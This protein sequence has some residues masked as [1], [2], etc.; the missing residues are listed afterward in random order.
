MKFILIVICLFTFILSNENK[1]ILG[2]WLREGDVSFYIFKNDNTY[3]AVEFWDDRY[4]ESETYNWKSINYGLWLIRRNKLCF[5][6]LEDLSNLQSNEQDFA[7]FDFQINKDY[8]IINYGSNGPSE[9]N[10]PVKFKKV[11]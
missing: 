9:R 4:G 3:R 10:L 11:K 2:V 5:Q 1:K 8:L 6:H 7:C